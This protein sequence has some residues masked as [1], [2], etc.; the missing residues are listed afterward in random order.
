M[1]CTVGKSGA[2][3]EQK[4]RRSLKMGRDQLLRGAG[5]RPFNQPLN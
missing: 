2:T 3:G 1:G 5:V 4:E